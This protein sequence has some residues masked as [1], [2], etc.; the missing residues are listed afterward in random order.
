MLCAVLVFF[1]FNV[2]FAVRCL[3]LDCINVLCVVC[4]FCFFVCCVSCVVCCLVCAVCRC[5]ALLVFK[6]VD[7]YVC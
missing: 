2:L 6:F 5:V 1:C 3:L 4:Y 7:V